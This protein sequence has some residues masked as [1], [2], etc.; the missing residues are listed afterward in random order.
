MNPHDAFERILASL[1][2]AAID[3]AHWPVAAALI[4]EACGLQGHSLGVGEGSGND[5]RVNFAGFYRRG[6]RRRDLER[7]YLEVYFPHDERPPRLRKAPEGQLIHVPDL[8]SEAE[9]KSS[10][11]YNEGLPR[12]DSQNGLAVRLAV[13]DGLR[14]LWVFGNPLGNG[15]WQSAQL[16]LIERLLPHIRQLVVVRQ[17]LAAAGA[18]DAGLTGLLDNSRIGV[19]QL[20]RSGRVVAANAPALDLLR[21]G[22]GLSDKDGALHAWLPADSERLRTLIGGALPG[23]WGEAPSGGSMTL[24]RPSDPA[25]LGL[26]VS[27]VG[28]DRADFGGRR[29]AALVL[30]VDPAFPPRIDPV[31]VAEAFGLTA[32]E[33]R[34]ASLLAEGRSVA[35]IAV[36]TGYR[37]GYVRRLLKGVYKKQE[38][39][40]QVALVPRILALDALPRR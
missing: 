8:Y 39:S 19:V 32:S 24:R 1:H 31:R 40:G 17:A 23:L 28:G 3:D 14:I 18:S 7:E 6:E 29:V 22:E 25:P 20:D 15:V 33:G 13:P 16:R 12:L 4:G 5:V 27:P 36:R 10:F 38:V 30:V 9:M 37:P 11:V 35:D 2:Q 34:V 21:R 26:H